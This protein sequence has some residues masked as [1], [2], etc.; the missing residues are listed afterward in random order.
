MDK[1]KQIEEIKKVLMETC[2]RTRSMQEDCMQD[3]YAEALYTKGYR[4]ASEIFEEISNRIEFAVEVVID[5]II[6]EIRKHRKIYD[7]DPVWLPTKSW[8]KE[9]SNDLYKKFEK[10]FKQENSK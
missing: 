7:L 5:T 3:H 8:L 2:K 1:D 6:S 10:I 9:T 4:K